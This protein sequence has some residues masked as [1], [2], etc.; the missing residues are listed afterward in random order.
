MAT[1]IQIIIAVQTRRL[2]PL[3]LPSFYGPPVRV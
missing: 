3:L 1:I 2:P